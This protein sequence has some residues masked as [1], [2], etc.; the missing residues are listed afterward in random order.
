MHHR[1]IRHEEPLLTFA[2]RLFLFA[3]KDSL[4][5]IMPG[6]FLFR[7]LDCGYLYG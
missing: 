3:K 7:T 5:T 1:R 6:W 2:S 4:D